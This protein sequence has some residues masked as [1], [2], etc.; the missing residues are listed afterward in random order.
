M[1]PS[2]YCN[3]RK[4]SICTPH[5]SAFALHRS[6]V[7]TGWLCVLK[8]D[9]VVEVLCGWAVRSSSLVLVASLKE[10]EIG[11]RGLLVVAVSTDRRDL[12]SLFSF[13]ASVRRFSRLSMWSLCSRFMEVSLVIFCRRSWFSDINPLVLSSRS[14]IYS[15][16]R[17]LERAADCLFFNNLSCLFLVLSSSDL[18][19]TLNLEESLL[20]SLAAC[21]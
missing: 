13:L 15:F 2:I 16:L 11:G 20:R 7:F 14:L 10:G 12:R 18:N 6:Y 9:V 21:I 19:S 17:C 4:P 1:H 5:D 3:E 8:A